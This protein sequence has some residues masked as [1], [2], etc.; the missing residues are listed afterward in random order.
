MTVS[1]LFAILGQAWLVK[2]RVIEPM[3]INGGKLYKENYLKV[4]FNIKINLNKE[5]KK[6]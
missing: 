6:L 5:V 4:T 2:V 1:K 3:I